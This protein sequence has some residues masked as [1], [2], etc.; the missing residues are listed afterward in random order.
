MRKAETSRRFLAL[1]LGILAIAAIGKAQGWWKGETEKD[2]IAATS[3]AAASPQ[4]GYP[5]YDD[6]WLLARLVSGEAHSE[7]YVGQ[8]AV[9]AVVINRVQSPRFP[10]TV[11]GVIFEPD[12][13]ESVSNGI[14]WALPPTDENM[15]AAQAALDGWDP[16]YGALF[17]WNPAKVV[18]PWIWTR[19]IITSIGRHV[20]GR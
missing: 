20:F 5:T 3:R 18:S 16:T 17:F 7:P 4:V 15:A 1:V 11:P 19:N 12:A 13:F 10:P 2:L 14:M 8:V 9:A 6:L